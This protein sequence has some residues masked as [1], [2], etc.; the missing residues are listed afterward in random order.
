MAD[1]FI[2]NILF[3]VSSASGYLSVRIRWAMVPEPLLLHCKERIS[4]WL[5]RRERGAI[6]A[7]N[8]FLKTKVVK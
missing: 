4:A 2:P 5:S 3:Q 8:N 6:N 7:I 1:C